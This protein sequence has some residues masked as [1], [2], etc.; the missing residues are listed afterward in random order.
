MTTTRINPKQITIG[1]LEEE[2]LPPI[3]TGGAV[4]RNGRLIGGAVGATEARS[5]RPLAA[6]SADAPSVP[7]QEK[8]AA[9]ERRIK[10][11]AILG[12]GR[13]LYAILMWMMRHRDAPG[14]GDLEEW[15]EEAT[16]DHPWVAG[17]RLAEPAAEPDM[18]LPAEPTEEILQSVAENTAL[19]QMAVE[20]AEE[21]QKTSIDDWLKAEFAEPPPAPIPP[22][23]PELLQAQ[24][25][26]WADA[27]QPAP[28]RVRRTRMEMLAAAAQKRR[29]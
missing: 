21:V 23:E 14:Y 17:E 24:K 12:D 13:V 7:W 2:E 5:G 19:V 3:I 27:N 8:V 28:R 6:D 22:T 25:E 1:P 18:E 9:Q 4:W 29:R 15:M 26:A 11:A 20:A 16:A 10:D